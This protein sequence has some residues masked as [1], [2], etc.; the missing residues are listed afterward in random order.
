MTVLLQALLKQLGT[1]NNCGLASALLFCSTS[2]CSPCG[3]LFLVFEELFF[4][5]YSD[6][7][8][9]IA[10][11]S[12][13]FVVIKNVQKLP[14]SYLQVQELSVNQQESHETANCSLQHK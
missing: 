11:L 12:Q 14:P 5:F 1:Q 9:R 3:K 4:E 13:T 2:D 10:R 8:E 6:N 7:L